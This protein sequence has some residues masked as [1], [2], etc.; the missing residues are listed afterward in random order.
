MFR[1]ILLATCLCGSADMSS[2]VGRA[3]MFTSCASDIEGHVQ[4]DEGGKNN[5]PKVTVR[6]TIKEDTANLTSSASSSQP[7]SEGSRA[8]KHSD[9]PL[10][11]AKAQ[12]GSQNAENDMS[13]PASVCSSNADGAGCSSVD[14][15]RTLLGELWSA[16]TGKHEQIIGQMKDVLR[17][18]GDHE[19]CK[20]SLLEASRISEQCGNSAS[21]Y[22]TEIAG[23]ELE[24]E[25][26]R[27][28]EIADKLQ[29]LADGLLIE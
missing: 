1:K 12:S 2:E 24:K 17:A 23:D 16:D 8:S 5:G 18:T 9:G 15:L 11:S 25:E 3:Q 22:W 26:K 29:K 19:A 14:R 21:C 6:S 20:S 10:D 7:I 28:Y 4:H 13:K 27:C